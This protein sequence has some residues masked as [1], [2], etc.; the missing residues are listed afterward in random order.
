MIKKIFVYLA[1]VS[2]ILVFNFI[3]TP[4]IYG[5]SS[6]DQYCNPGTAWVTV[7]GH[8][9]IYQTFTPSQNR[10]TRVGLWME[11]DGDGTVYLRVRKGGDTIGYDYRSEPSGY[12]LIYFDFDEIE[13]TP[14]ATYILFVSTGAGNTSLHWR[15][16]PIGSGCYSGGTAYLDGAEKD[17][18]WGFAS[19]GFTYT[20]PQ[21][22]EED[23]KDQDGNQP[24]SSPKESSD[25][26][27]YSG[28]EGISSGTNEAP[29]LQT[30]SS[31]AVAKG[32]KAG[33]L[34]NDQGGAIKLTWK[35]TNPIEGYQGHK[36]FRSTKKRVKSFRNITIAKKN[37]KEFVD[38]KVETGRE[39]YYFVRTYQNSSESKSSNTAVA[40]AVDNLAP[41]V[42]ENFRIV[43]E[44]DQGLKFSWDGNSESDMAGYLLTA[45]RKT[46]EEEGMVAEE[47]N[48]TKDVNEYRLVCT[49]HPALG[50][51]TNYN[52]YLQAKDI[53]DNISDRTE[54]VAVAKEKVGSSWIRYLILA[55]LVLV[56]LAS[57]YLLY[58]LNKKKLAKSSQRK[59][60]NF[61]KK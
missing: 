60:D 5:A 42:P 56:L 10:L 13:L 34:P 11:G 52:F 44:S 48:L 8:S 59:M 53:H 58:R 46:E 55:I 20:P 19:Y 57:I 35:K 37:V 54:A 61:S 49:D 4:P 23:G 22:P 28:Q 2:L 50:Q 32:L 15:R 36:I 38:N 6:V 40:T 25:E 7:N 18:D 29:S 21:G 14:S 43:E 33:D 16:S 39:Y 17:Y 27:A 24:G 31:L 41:V 45:Y 3:Q 12:Q 47:I 30:D 1:V 51:I 26:T 9:S